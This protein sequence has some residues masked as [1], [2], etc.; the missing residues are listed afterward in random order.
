MIQSKPDVE[1]E[2]GHCDL[3]VAMIVDRLVTPRSKFGSVRTVAEIGH[4]LV[5]AVPH[6]NWNKA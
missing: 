3:F 4:R 5:D 6:G 2:Q 1:A